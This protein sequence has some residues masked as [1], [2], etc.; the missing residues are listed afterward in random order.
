MPCAEKILTNVVHHAY[1]RPVAADDMPALLALYKQGAESGGFEQGIR[2]ALQKVLVSPN[3]L[4]RVEFD[5]ADAS[6]GGVRQVSDI[7]LAS[8]LSFF[9]WSSLPDDELLAVAEGG[10][11]RDPAV[12]EAQVR[13]MLADPRSQSLV[14]NFAG[15]WLFLRNIPA[16][17]PDPSAFPTWDENL[18][19]AMRKETELWLESQ[20]REDRSVVDL[21]TTDYTF[22]NQRLAEHYG[23][24]GIWGNDFR[25]V[26]VEDPRRRGLLGQ[27]SIMAV[28]SY[29]NR[30]APTVRGKWVLEPA[31]AALAA[32]KSPEEAAKIPNLATTL[33][34]AAAWSPNPKNPPL[35]LDMAT[36]DGQV[37]QDV[38]AKW[39]A[40]APLAFVDQYIGNLKQYKA[41]AID[42]GDQD[43]VRVDAKKLHDILDSYG[44]PNSF[45]IYP[46]THTSAVAVR[47]QNFVM[48]FFSKNLCSGKTCQ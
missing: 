19:Q 35:Y 12:L 5:P 4:F 46:G 42:V 36:K 37:Q 17:Q 21:L 23:M 40:N 33:A 28:T 25:R 30:T 44:I 27:A 39:A 22:V 10:K 1:R 15:Q 2:L 47:F 13:R 14:Q 7:E 41:I 34:V 3:F 6:P 16:V 29:P 48:P 8:R 43:G 38:V 31:D 9:L 24:K 18:R 26:A 20:M 45:E 32:A 11:L